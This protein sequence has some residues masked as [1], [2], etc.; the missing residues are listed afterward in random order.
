MHA[1]FDEQLETPEAELAM[2]KALGRRI[3]APFG[4]ALLRGDAGHCHRAVLA[5]R[6]AA[7]EG[8]EIRDL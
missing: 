3:G 1:I 6:L 4:P 8:F 7:A 2:E 5:E